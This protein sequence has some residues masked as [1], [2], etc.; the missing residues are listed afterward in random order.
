MAMIGKH[1]KT[2]ADSVDSENIKA[3]Y[4]LNKAAAL[5]LIGSRLFIKASYLGHLSAARQEV[6]EKA[7]TRLSVRSGCSLM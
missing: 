1:T 7:T 6:F 3:H 2:G 5:C 4:T